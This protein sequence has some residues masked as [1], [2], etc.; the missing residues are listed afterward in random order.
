MLCD[1]SGMTDF[2]CGHWD[3]KLLTLGYLPLTQNIVFTL[4]DY[5]DVRIF[6]NRNGS[7]SRFATERMRRITKYMYNVSLSLFEL[8]HDYGKILSRRNVA[9]SIWQS[10]SKRKVLRLGSSPTSCFPHLVTC[11]VVLTVLRVR[12]HRVPLTWQK[13]EDK[14]HYVGK[15]FHG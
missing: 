1:K 14:F 2:I 13:F 8:S 11:Y 10:H 12:G 9:Q 3:C 5:L 7:F 6:N 15:G 4:A